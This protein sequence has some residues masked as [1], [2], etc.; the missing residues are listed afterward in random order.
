VAGISLW[1]AGRSFAAL[2]RWLEPQGSFSLA[3]FA[4]GFARVTT[5]GAARQGGTQEF[6][7]WPLAAQRVW[8]VPLSYREV[9]HGARGNCASAQVAASRTASHWSATN[10][11]STIRAAA[12]LSAPSA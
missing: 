1:R 6:S 3:A 11:S 10:A 9:P 2:A 4:S 12:S 7:A 8:G 5:V